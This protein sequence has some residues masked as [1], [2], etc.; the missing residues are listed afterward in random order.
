MMLKILMPI[1]TGKHPF[2]LQY[3]RK[4]TTASSMFFR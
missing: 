3:N 4:A 2:Q 1:E